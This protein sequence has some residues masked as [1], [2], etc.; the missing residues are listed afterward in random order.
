MGAN[1]IMTGDHKNGNVTGNGTRTEH[2][3][4][5]SELSY[6]RLFEAAQDG[7]LILDFY[8]GRITDV[9]PFLCKL[10]GFS[11]SEMVGNTVGELSPFR[12]MEPNQAMLERLQQRGYVRYEDLPLERRDGRKIAVE[13]VS[14]VYQAGDKKV[15]Q[16]NIRDITERKKAEQ[17]LTLLNT[18]VSNLNDIVLVTEADPIDEPGPRIVFVNEAFERI[19]GYTSA[20]TIGRSPRFLQG[21][22]TERRILAEIRQALVQQQPLRRQ[23]INYRKDGTEY[24]LDIDIVPILNAAGKCTNFAAIGRNITEEK[25]SEE[26]RARL[27]AIVECSEDAI[28]S[29]SLDG[30]IIS[31][32]QGAERL[33]GYTAEEI[34]GQP[35]SILFIPEHNGEY[36]QIMEKVRR[37]ERVAAYETARRRKDGSMINV[38]VAI[39][40]IE[41]RNGELVGASSISRDIT[42]VKRLEEQ[43]RQ[44]QK[45]EAI[46]RLA[47]GM[48]HDFNNQLTVICGY[49]QLLLNTAHDE[50]ETDKLREIKKAG[51][52]AASLTQQLLAFSRN[53]VLEPKVLD[54]NI[55]VGES[56]KMLRRLLGEDIDLAT[57]LNPKL[58][59][60]ET[61]PSQLEQ[62]LM[63]L[64]INARD[65]MPQGGKLTIE[66]ANAVLDRTY[67]Q[68]HDD[69]KP[70]NYVMLAVRDTGCGMDE[71]TQGHIFEPFFTTKEL[72]K[73]TG[74][75][76]AMIHGFINQSGG[77]ILVESEVGLGST[78]SIYL[79]EV[80]KVP[81][82]PEN[83]PQTIEKMPHG[84]ETILLVE[85]DDAVRTFASQV[86]QDCGYTI[87]EAASGQEAIQLLKKH[88]EQVHMLVSD[89][90]MP[91][92]S[93]REVAEQVKALIPA[94]KVL[95]LS[96]YTD[97]AVIRHGILASEVAFLQKPF[98][99]SE[100]GLKVRNV[101]D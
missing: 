14:N 44:S 42:R 32:N 29:K 48:A 31:W 47:G 8:T 7:I 35:M 27:A 87:I 17:R 41:I 62:V 86:L 96:G 64:V 28:I 18:C 2:A 65:A 33:Y 40:P 15:I 52:R 72:G 23:I 70:G 11:H 90:V 22:K 92:L 46:G 51:E 75:G 85:D 39:A 77:H 79:P 94:I 67:C 57:V 21:E 89:V 13:F 91:S 81:R 37:G 97:D 98:T 3:L 9:N 26:E 76:L 34:I 6:R 69:V 84:D 58:G 5:A 45:L 63:N 1:R 100:L 50:P 12:D 54:L 66:T 56:E 99:P 61:D 25:K 30:I 93:G 101:L 10:L 4:R 43:F 19:T 38:S 88:P 68:I 53:Q 60:V 49:T 16:C 36:L 74:L 73:G 80:Q 20:E 71:Q 82:S 83:L 95:F 59:S 24:W 78:I 55:V